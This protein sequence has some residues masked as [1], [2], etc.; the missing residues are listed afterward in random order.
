MPTGTLATIS[1]SAPSPD[2]RVAVQEISRLYQDT[3]DC[4]Q[5]LSNRPMMPLAP[6]K[7]TFSPDDLE[8][9]ISG[10][11]TGRVKTSVSVVFD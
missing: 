8:P 2:G 9:L 1:L 10:T 4:V 5:T 6:G 3:G 11:Q 7:A